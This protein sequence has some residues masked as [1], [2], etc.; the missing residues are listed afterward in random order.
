MAAH[1][2]EISHARTAPLDEGQVAA[3]RM[4]EGLTAMFKALKPAK[5]ARRTNPEISSVPEKVPS[6]KW[7]IIGVL[8]PSADASATYITP[9]LAGFRT[10]AYY[11][12]SSRF[13]D[14]VK[15]KC[16]KLKT[17]RPCVKN[18]L[19]ISAIWGLN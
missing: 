4:E 14:G 17:Y 19:N 3:H 5:G 11:M 13:C 8:M 1:V 7:R 2:I 10:G 9:F 6:Y 18:W 12:A 16:Q 15:G